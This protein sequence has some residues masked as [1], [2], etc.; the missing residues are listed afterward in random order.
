MNRWTA[1]LA[2]ALLLATAHA[3]HAQAADTTS[4]PNSL[5]A[6]ARSFS[7]GIPQSGSGSFGYWKMT[8]DRTALGVQADVQL[9][10]SNRTT[11]GFPDGTGTTSGAALG[12]NLR[13]YA[14]TDMRVAPF[15]QVGVNAGYRRNT[16]QIDSVS[17]AHIHSVVGGVQ[18]GVGVEWFPVREVSVAGMTGLSLFAQR[19]SDHAM[20]VTDVGFSTFTSSLA[21]HIY[22]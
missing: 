1:P 9:S 12:V 5:A 11:P 13:R 16:A 7:F 8:S 21:L 14:R 6:G 4:R 20:H 2:A 15:A 22:F 18:A 3:G 19:S 10:H 17:L